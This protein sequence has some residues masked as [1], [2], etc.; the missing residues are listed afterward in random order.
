MYVF[1]VNLLG[2]VGRYNNPFKSGY[3]HFEQKALSM[4]WRREC[5]D[6]IQHVHEL[7][8][9]ERSKDDWLAHIH[10]EQRAGKESWETYC[11]THGLPTCHVGMWF[12]GF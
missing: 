1:L 5:K 4:F 7:T 8:K 10:M 2:T 12:P 6:R 3:E 11:F 9:P